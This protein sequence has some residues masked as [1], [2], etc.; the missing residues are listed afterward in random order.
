MKDY[1]R[2][3]YKEDKPDH[4][5]RHAGTNDQACGNNVER[6]RNLLLTYQKDW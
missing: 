5:I 6:T 3:C 4:L 2:S 1:S